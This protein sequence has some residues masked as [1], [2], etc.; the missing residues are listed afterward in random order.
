VAVTYAFGLRWL[1]LLSVSMADAKGGWRLGTGAKCGQQVGIGS[2][3]GVERVHEGCAHSVQSITGEEE[4]AGR[5]SERFL[6][7]MASVV[8][9]R[10][11]QSDGC[12]TV[13]GC[14]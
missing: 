7:G 8:N 4:A 5:R 3:S 14:W 2:S 10:A 13:A 9:D 11:W 12:E 6:V 1:G